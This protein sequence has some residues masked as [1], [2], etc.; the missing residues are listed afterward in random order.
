VKFGTRGLQKL[1]LKVFDF[2]ENQLRKGCAYISLL[3]SSL[4]KGEWSTSLARRFS[5]E[6]RTTDAH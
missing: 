4:D 2:R 3:T 6:K 5:L 1:L